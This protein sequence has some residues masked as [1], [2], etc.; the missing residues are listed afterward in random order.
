[1]SSSKAQYSLFPSSKA[2]VTVK[3]HKSYH[4]TKQEYN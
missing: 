4:K 1:M 2:S 3:Q